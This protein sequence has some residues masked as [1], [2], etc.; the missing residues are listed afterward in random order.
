MKKLTALFCAL[1]LLVSVFAM[2]TSAAGA[3]NEYEQ[4]VLDHLSQHVQLGKTDFF[5]PEEYITQAKNYFL[6][7]DM[8]E[9]QSKDVIAHVNTGIEALKA[10]SVPQKD[11]DLKILPVSVKQ[12]VLKAGQD[13]C[14]AVNCNLV[15]NTSTEKVVITATDSQGKPVTVFDAAAIIKT[16]G[17]EINVTAIAVTVSVLVVALGAAVIASKKAKLF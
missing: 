6:T 15:Y 14:A 12:V 7:I 13:A 17:S 16:T 10:A 11:F 3:I 8:T 2:S 1:I 4:K 5:I 9:P